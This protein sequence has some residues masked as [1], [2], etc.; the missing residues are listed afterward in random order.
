MKAKSIKGKAPDEI[1]TALAESMSDGFKPTLA[2]VY[3]S[4][5]QDRGK[6]RKL[7]D[8]KSIA[9]YGATTG[10]EFIDATT[11]EGSIAILLLQ[12]NP[13]Y[14][15]IQFAELKS[16]VERNI[17]KM[18][19]EEALKKFKRPAFLVAGSNLLTDAEQLVMGFSDAAGE[20]VTVF[21]GMAGDD[22][23]FT[24][25]FVFTNNKESSRGIVTVVFNEDKINVQ[26]TATCGWKA[27]GT[28]KTV[29]KSEGNKVFTIDDT[30]ALD[31]TVKYSGISD[32]EKKDDD[33]F[34]KITAVFP[35]QLQRKNDLPIMRPGLVVDWNDKSFICAGSI[36]QGSKIK[37]CLPPDF[38]VIESLVKEC[39]VLKET[40]IPEADA[41][42]MVNCVGRIIALGPMISQEIEGIQKVWNA[43]MV[44]FFSN[45]EFTR[46]NGGKLEMHNLTNCCVVLNEK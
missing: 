43:P 9:I 35:L 39:E 10:G 13:D 15:F 33:F 31:I 11:E 38:D 24:D 2:I 4:V 12:V 17:T 29:T 42:I 22:L 5:K 34:K 7:L 6:V 32:L 1:K 20:D 27:A 3:L 41:L 25:Q 36:P 16:K 28:E 21:G 18:L 8:E 45:A 26:G 44:G 19:C 37:F 14:F 23:T 40:K 46:A 30:P